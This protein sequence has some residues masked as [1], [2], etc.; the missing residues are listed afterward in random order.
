MCGNMDGE[1]G[2]D[3]MT[4]NGITTSMTNLFGDSYNNNCGISSGSQQ[5]L[6]PCT[7][8]TNNNGVSKDRV[9]IGLY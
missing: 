5:D 9:Q 8:R 4:P 1:I 7:L 2:N 3:F 6:N